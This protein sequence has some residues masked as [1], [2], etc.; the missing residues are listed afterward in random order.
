MKIFRKKVKCVTIET[1]KLVYQS[2]ETHSVSSTDMR[3]PYS[4]DMFYEN[5]AP[6]LEVNYAWRAKKTTY[7]GR[8]F[9]LLNACASEVFAFELKNA[10]L[11]VDLP[12]KNL[13]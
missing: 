9:L 11:G 3:I 13:I 1:W 4:R 2:Y 12:S 10:S 7:F 5:K 6:F 8:I